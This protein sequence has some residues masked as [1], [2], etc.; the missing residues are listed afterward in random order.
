MQLF[1]S[2]ANMQPT[3]M[4]WCS[5]HWQNTEHLFNQVESTDCG[6]PT[7]WTLGQS[8]LGR[9]LANT[10]EDKYNGN[11][12]HR[13]GSHIRLFFSIHL[14]L[15]QL[16]TKL[17]NSVSDKSLLGMFQNGSICTI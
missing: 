11:I 8:Q 16:K 14:C 6:L 9:T 3:A 13:C 17:R 5:G 10:Q 4:C 1:S 15:S 12:Q 7:H 2:V